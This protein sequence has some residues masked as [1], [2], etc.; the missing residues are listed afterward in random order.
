MRAA[1]IHQV[2]VVDVHVAEGRRAIVESAMAPLMESISKIGLQMPIC[3]RV[4]D[5]M[6]LPGE[7]AVCGVPVLVA[8]RHRLEAARRLGIEMIPAVQMNDETDARLWE[9]SENLHRAELSAVD[10]AEQ[11]NE[12]RV[13]TVNK[14]GAHDV[15][16]PGGTEDRGHYKTAATLGVSR[17]T[18][19]R[20]EKIAALPKETR[21]QAREEGWTQKRLLAAAAPPKPV[22][23]APEPHNDLEAVEAQVKRLMAAWNAAGPEARDDFLARI[24]A[25]V[26][27]RTAAGR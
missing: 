15:P 8:G 13:L 24:D 27:D 22:P 6:E 4:V 21:D 23:I 9:I 7:G 17:T 2:R 19:D 5:E 12:W 14:R 1:T 11:I 18:V 3:V 16:P 25:P 20:A 26:F 10:R